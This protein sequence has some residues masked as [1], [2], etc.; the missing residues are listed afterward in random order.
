MDV[1]PLDSL[2]LLVQPLLHLINLL[3]DNQ[4]VLLVPIGPPL[5]LD[6]FDRTVLIRGSIGEASVSADLLQVPGVSLLDDFSQLVCL[7]VHFGYDGQYLGVGESADILLHDLLEGRLHPVE[8][9]GGDVSP[10]CLVR[11][12]RNSLL[13]VAGQSVLLGGRVVGFER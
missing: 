8:Q 6:E 1:L 3:L 10:E 5:H 11:Q 12:N 7:V 9:T 4:L 2:D 13:A